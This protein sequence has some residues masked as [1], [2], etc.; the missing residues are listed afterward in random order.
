MT[1]VC[2]CEPDRGVTSLAATCVKKT[3]SKR[4]KD[5]FN[6]PFC[7]V[8]AIIRT[9]DDKT[10]YDH[11]GLCPNAS[12]ADI[13]RAY[14]ELSLRCALS[15]V[16]D[17]KISD[18][19]KHALLNQFEAGHF[20]Y[21][22]LRNA[23]SKIEY[24]EMIAKGPPYN[25]VHKENKRAVI[26]RNATNTNGSGTGVL[27]DWLTRTKSRYT[28]LDKVDEVTFLTRFPSDGVSDP[29]SETLRCLWKDN[30]FRYFNQSWDISITLNPC[31]ARPKRFTV[32]NAPLYAEKYGRED[33]NFIYFVLRQLDFAR[34]PRDI[35][36]MHKAVLVDIKRAPW[37]K[38]HV[39][40][41]ET[42][43]IG[44]DEGSLSLMVRIL[45][46][47]RLLSPDKEPDPM[48]IILNAEDKFRFATNIVQR[49]AS[50][51]KIRE[52]MILG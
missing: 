46:S 21:R 38:I 25:H 40:Q 43:L 33:E 47:W 45:T 30:V 3:K 14:V 7:K 36:L 50:K 39:K 48:T 52:S 15:Q 23:E 11:L 4:Y 2:S 5:S 26:Q 20:A 13:H 34:S 29:H 28:N 6:R 17:M 31:Y 37:Y 1:S 51:V 19:K 24:D 27:D 18:N 49:A 41:I 16:K 8:G 44:Q 10:H 42:L 32:H 9:M 22:T 35:G 12:Q